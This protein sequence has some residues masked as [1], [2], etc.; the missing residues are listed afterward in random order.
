MTRTDTTFTVDG[1]TCAAWLYTPDHA[2]SSSGRPIIVM[3]HGLGAVKEMRLDAFAE[4][5]TAAGYACLVFDYRHFGASTG[6]PR[7]LLD[8]KHQLQDWKAAVA[9]ARTLDGVDPDKVIAWG[10]SFG[11][12]HAIITAAQD[13][14]I[15]A[16]IAQCPFTNGISST[17]A[18]PVATSTK[19]TALAIADAAGALL[20]RDPVMVAVYGPPGST[21]LMTAEDSV[22]GIERMIPDGFDAPREVASRFALQ[23]VKHF[24]GRYARNVECPILFAIC[25]PDTV[26]P[27][28]PTK[29]YAAQA[30]RGE[31]KL[32]DY[33][34]FDIYVG[35]AFEVNVADQLEFL[36]TH[37][38]ANSAARG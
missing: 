23:I 13:K 16:A 37:V 22:A 1:D 34:H 32:Y 20:G 24:P 36:N 28:G 17:A 2:P 18:I 38:P 29:K 27:A 5:F 6:E 30:P 33:G 21:A 3:A 26:A 11:G 35:E 8:I 9:Y 10:T 15:A 14:R 19:L 25:E 7:Q 12:G 4:R 31:V